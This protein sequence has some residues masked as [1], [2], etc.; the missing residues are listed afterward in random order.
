MFYVLES[1][2]TL[3]YLQ[4]KMAEQSSS[5]CLAVM[6]WGQL[7]VWNGKHTLTQ[8]LHLVRTLHRFFFQLSNTLSVPLGKIVLFQSLEGHF[9]A[10]GVYQSF[11]DSPTSAWCSLP[12]EDSFLAMRLDKR[13]VV[14]SS[15]TFATLYR[16][17]G[18]F[19]AVQVGRQQNSG[20]C[21]VCFI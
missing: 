19:V 11:V 20:N 3:K 6:V 2:V 17:Q 14:G 7:S 13:P 18:V 1:E 21:R 5:Q 9:L 8:L 15:H 4:M 16:W 12:Y 10:M